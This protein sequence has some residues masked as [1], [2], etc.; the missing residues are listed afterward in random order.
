MVHQDQD[1]KRLL[2]LGRHDGS[3]GRER[4]CRSGYQ[5]KT[6][7]IGQGRGGVGRLIFK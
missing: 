6:I 7:G 4:V 2:R 1:L 5:G 3:I